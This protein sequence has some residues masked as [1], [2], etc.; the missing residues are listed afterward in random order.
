MN[1]SNTE[2]A[3]DDHPL[4]ESFTFIQL[5]YLAVIVFESNNCIRNCIF[6]MKWQCFG[7]EDQK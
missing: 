5:I 4:F 1:E 3:F 7:A 6:N 2:K